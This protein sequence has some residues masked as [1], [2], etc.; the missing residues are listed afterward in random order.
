MKRTLTLLALLA[1]V[2]I[3]VALGAAKGGTYAGKT[4]HKNPLTI[5]VAKSGTAGIFKICDDTKGVAFK[6]TAAGTF[7]VVGTRFTQVWLKASGKFV[8]SK[9]TGKISQVTIC[10]GQPQAFALSVR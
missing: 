6:I 7:T 10:D 9:V 3:P 8:G 1:L 5:V 4:A 2:A